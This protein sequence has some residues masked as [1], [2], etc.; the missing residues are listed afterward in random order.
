M[1]KPITNGKITRWL[2]L[3]QEFNITVLDRPGRESQV[4]DFLSRI[5]TPVEIVPILD[6]FPHGHLLAISVITPWYDDIAN[7]LSIGKLPPHFTSREKRK[8][9]RESARYTWLNGDLF[10]TSSNLIIRRCVRQ[11]EIIDILKACHDK[12]CGGHFADKRTM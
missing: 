10:Y 4:E 2:L 8:I 12:P 7:N 3:M 1:N 9:I 5:H 6:N 11:D